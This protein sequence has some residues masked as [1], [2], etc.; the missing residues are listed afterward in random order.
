MA[1]RRMIETRRHP[2]HGR[3]MRDYLKVRR[4]DQ[5]DG[6]VV[7]VSGGEVRGRLEETR[8][9]ACSRAAAKLLQ[10]MAQKKLQ[11]WRGSWTAP[12]QS[13]SGSSSSS[14]SSSSHPALRPRP[15]RSGEAGCDDCAVG[16]R[17]Y[18]AQGA[19]ARLERPSAVAILPQTFEAVGSHRAEPLA[20]PRVRPKGR[21]TG[22][23]ARAN[24]AAAAN[25]R[26]PLAPPQQARRRQ[27]SHR[28]L[29]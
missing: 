28:W 27:P 13:R 14:S 19:T 20:A 9:A 24:A 16:G 22:I 5:R 17:L 23:V 1:G 12:G 21:G 15:N 25:I 2:R 6:L 7:V 29:R 3:L 10:W 4:S 11:R 8:R 18:Q 26:R